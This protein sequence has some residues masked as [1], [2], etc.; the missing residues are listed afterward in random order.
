MRERKQE[1]K[2]KRDGTM[3]EGKGEETSVIIPVHTFFVNIVGRKDV[4]ADLIW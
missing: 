3:E 4:L 1:W 2:E